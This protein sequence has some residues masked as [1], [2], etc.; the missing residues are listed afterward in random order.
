MY[1]V[2]NDAQNGG[3]NFR[4]FWI[5]DAAFARGFAKIDIRAQVFKD[6]ARAGDRSLISR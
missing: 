4:D 6:D 5:K 1:R 2:I 3:I